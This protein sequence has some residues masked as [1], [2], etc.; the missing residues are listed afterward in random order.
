MLELGRTE[1][2]AHGAKRVPAEY[3]S[4]GGGG[5]AHNP[6]LLPTEFLLSV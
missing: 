3:V 6:Q 1:Q 2:V 4:M 5:M